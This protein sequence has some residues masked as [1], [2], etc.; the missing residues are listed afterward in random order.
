M[1]SPL[2]GSLIASYYRN[3]KYQALIAKRKKLKVSVELIANNASLLVSTAK[4]YTDTQTSLK[5]PKASILL[6]TAEL[7]SGLIQ[8]R[9]DISLINKQGSSPIVMSQFL[10]M[11]IGES[12]SSFVE[13][14]PDT[15]IS[16]CVL[17]DSA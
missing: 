12:V 9:I 13:G 7:S 3:K 8:L 17:I 10:T 4:V 2:G 16:V 14:Q 15:K 1:S 11:E 5:A 6:T